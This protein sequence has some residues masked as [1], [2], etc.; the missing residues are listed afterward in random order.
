MANLYCKQ[1]GCRGDGMITAI[2]LDQGRRTYRVTSCDCPKCTSRPVVLITKEGEVLAEP[3]TTV[4]SLEA[5]GYRDV[6]EKPEP[7][8]DDMKWLAAG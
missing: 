2:Y 8:V 6:F 7:L 5:D 4:S 3:K 1:P